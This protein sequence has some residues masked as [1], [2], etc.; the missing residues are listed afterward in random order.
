MAYITVFCLLIV[1]HAVLG[2][3]VGGTIPHHQR[4]WLD[5]SLPIAARVELLLKNMTLTEKICQLNHIFPPTLTYNALPD[6]YKQGGVGTLSIESNPPLN[7]EQCDMSCRIATVRQMQLDLLQNTRLGIPATFLIETSHCGAA[8][9]TVF[10]MGVTQ[11]ASW[12]VDLVK[13]VG[14]AI[15]IEARSWGGDRGL[16]P[17]INVVTDPRF[18]RT[19]ENFGEDPLLVAMMAEYAVMG[20]Q[21]GRDS[22]S[23]YLPNYNQTI[24]AEAKHCCVYG[25]GGYDGA[26]ADISEKTLHD[27]YLKP[28]RRFIKAGGRGMM[29]SHNELNS[30]QM[31]ANKEIFQD[32]FRGRWNY[33][34]LVHSDDGN[35]DQLT[36]TRTCANMTQCASL[37]L[38]AGVDQQFGG[39]AYSPDVLL[40]AVAN[41][42][43]SET[44]ITVSAGRVLQQKFAAGLFDGALPDPKNRPNINSQKH[45]DLARRV[46]EQSAILLNNN[47]ILPLNMNAIKTIGIVGPNA[48]CPTINQGPP[49]SGQCT[50]N[51]MLDCSDSAYGN[52]TATSA[53]E[54]CS[55][56]QADSKCA[57]AT[58]DT[59][60]CYFKAG[61]AYVIRNTGSVITLVD[62]GRVK[63]S[64]AYNPW[65]CQAQRAMLGGYSNLEMLY[66]SQNDNHGHVTTVLEAFQQNK[67]VRT[68]Y[69]EGCDVQIQDVSSFESALDVAR[70]SDVV[71]A[72]LG[73]SAEAIGGNGGVTCGEGVDRP[74]LDLPGV[75][76]QFL[77]ALIDV[78]KPVIVVLVH[79][80]PV[81]FGA[82][83]GGSVVSMFQGTPLNQRA[84]AVLA[85]WRP[86]CEGGSAIYNLITG[87]VSPSG[88]LAQAWPYAAGAV[89]AGRSSPWY[90]KW[91]SEMCGDWA[92]GTPRRPMY[93][94]G[95]GL[96]Y[97]QVEYLQS[98]AVVDT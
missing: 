34:G 55:L 59:N 74:S 98:S 83:H 63:V 21:G 37:A 43:V 23:D 9:G 12:D 86:G 88:R 71:V 4:P 78:G 29:P 30:V 80:R 68:L 85:A 13:Q 51:T 6:P 35:I 33:T 90:T 87:S 77:Q 50:V 97:L 15:A 46:T 45:R 26:A 60:L 58:F 42:V 11:G 66:D 31:H 22:P 2:M 56:C 38:P 5:A 39:V 47:G 65:T 27:I 40:P 67:N 7:P 72:V 61:C 17:E 57:V 54:C 10:P 53:A 32:L 75:Q 76:L 3:N 94:F 1:T 81:T 62:T 69:A 96:D 73:D 25:F 95:Y 84:A 92:L 49:A 79:G 18:G 28:W 44:D 8:G 64:Y 48:G 70:Q 82:D 20:L 93:P 16:S 14:Q 41:G 19:E 36:N 89:R 24:V 52:A 91:C